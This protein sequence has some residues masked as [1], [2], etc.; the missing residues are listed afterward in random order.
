M[1]I[2]AGSTPTFDTISCPIVINFDGSQ[3]W[4][5]VDNDAV[6]GSTPAFGSRMD[7]CESLYGIPRSIQAGRVLPFK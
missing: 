5:I 3:D 6:A 4:V 2:R 1:T 7:Q